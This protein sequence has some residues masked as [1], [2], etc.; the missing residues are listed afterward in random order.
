MSNPSDQL[1]QHPSAIPVGAA[2][3]QFEDFIYLVSHDV[4]Q[5]VRALLEVPQW[6]EEDLA[7]LDRAISPSLRENIDLMNT[8]TRRLDRMLI[9]LLIYS[10]IGRMQ[11]GSKVEWQHVIDATLDQIQLPAGFHLIRDIAAPSYFMGETDAHT[12][13]SSLITN[14]I[15]HHDRETGTIR[16]ATRNTDEGH[17]FSIEDD[18]PGIPLKHRKKIFDVMTTLKPRDHIEGSGMGLANVRKI[19]AHYRARIECDT[20]ACGRG[21]QVS[22]HFPQD[23]VATH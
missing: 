15:K 7:Q 10:R 2:A 14:A 18:G 1:E 23:K 9:D 4:R 3:Q 5:S 13:V 21:C 22:I 8:H 16:I 11:E 17:V 6:I 19:A 12:L 20:G